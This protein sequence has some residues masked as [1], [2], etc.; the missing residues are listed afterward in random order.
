M[1]RAEQIAERF[2]QVFFPLALRPRSL[3]FHIP[4]QSAGIDQG[5]L[6]G[7]QETSGVNSILA[8]AEICFSVAELNQRAGAGELVAARVAKSVNNDLQARLL[9]REGRYPFRVVAAGKSGLYNALV[10]AEVISLTDALHLIKE[11]SRAIGLAQKVYLSSAVTPEDLLY[12]P[13]LKG[14][15]GNMQEAMAKVEIRQPKLTVVSGKG[16]KVSGEVEIRQEII[17]QALRPYDE[18]AVDEALRELKVYRPFEI[19]LQPRGNRRYLIGA[20]AAGT[21]L[22]LIAY[23]AYG[24]YQRRNKLS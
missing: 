18:S 2:G 6:T 17:E 15:L 16:S 13:I 19:G 11:E 5:L 10:F 4:Y 20:M 14:F 9:E 3:R 23:E 1:R 22:A 21:I 24:R 12:T 8:E 7:K